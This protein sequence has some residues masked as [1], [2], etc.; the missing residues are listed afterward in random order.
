MKTFR[1]YEDVC[2]GEQK[3]R[4]EAGMDRG[5]RSS[6]ISK[7]DGAGMTGRS[8]ISAYYIACL[9]RG[10]DSRIPSA[11]RLGQLYEPCTSQALSVLYL[12]I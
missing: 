11:G 2:M 12:K 4:I 1:S 9:D 8:S 6:E 3:N 10:P 7:V 5:S